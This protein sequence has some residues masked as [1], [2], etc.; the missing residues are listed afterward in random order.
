MRVIEGGQ[1]FRMVINSII[2]ITSIITII[3]NIL[4]IIPISI[5]IDI[6]H[7]IIYYLLSH[8]N[9]QAELSPENLHVLTS[10]Y[11]D[12]VADFVIIE[13]PR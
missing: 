6:I 7:I 5:I 9:H 13:P 3:V 10:F 2:V 1:V 8:F 11:E 4:I 12:K